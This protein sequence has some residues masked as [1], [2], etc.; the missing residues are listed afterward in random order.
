MSTGEIGM[1][2]NRQIDNSNQAVENVIKNN[3]V[4]I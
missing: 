2:S 3:D 1:T 4:K